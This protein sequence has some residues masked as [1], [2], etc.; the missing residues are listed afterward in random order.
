MFPTCSQAFQ[1]AVNHEPLDHIYLEQK[2]PGLFQLVERL[3]G[4]AKLWKCFV[5]FIGPANPPET[6]A[7]AC[8]VVVDI[9]ERAMRADKAAQFAQALFENQ[10]LP[11]LLQALDDPNSAEAA[12]HILYLLSTHNSVA[13]WFS[14]DEVKGCALGCAAEVVFVILN[15]SLRAIACCTARGPTA[16]CA[17]KNGHSDA[18]LAALCVLL[19][20]GKSDVHGGVAR[21]QA[22]RVLMP[23]WVLVAARQ[24]AGGQLGGVVEQRVFHH[25]AAQL[26]DRPAASARSERADRSCKCFGV[27]AAANRCS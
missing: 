25:H 11:N 15:F 4:P 10:S 19:H 18:V 14:Q 7:M 16:G 9:Q 1:L 17:A 23:C 20:C 8:T 2:Y 26:L 12:A 24:R 5:R 3:G 13:E 27:F 22:T 6:R 21:K